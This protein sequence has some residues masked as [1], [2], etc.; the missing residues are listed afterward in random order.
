M[1]EK[2]KYESPTI[3]VIQIDLSDGIASSGVVTH[4]EIWGDL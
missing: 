3:E 4:E 2:N 1:E